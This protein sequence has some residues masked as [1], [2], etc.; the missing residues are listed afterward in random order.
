MEK[1][2]EE[3]EILSFDAQDNRIMCFPHII[4]ITVQHVLKRMSSVEAP[5]TDDDSE[6]L[7]DKSNTEDNHGIGQTFDDACAQDPLARLH[8]IVM[9]IQSYGQPRDAFMTWIETRNNSGLIVVNNRPVEIP[10][11]QLL[12]DV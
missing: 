10:P 6:D 3:H 4:N 8:K 5:E 1:L 7:I 12:R 2:F 11:R 9:K